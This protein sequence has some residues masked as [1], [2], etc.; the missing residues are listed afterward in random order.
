VIIGSDIPDIGPRHIAAAFGAL[1][2][3]NAVFGPADDG[4]YW[5]IGLRRRPFRPRLCGPVRWSSAH[6][7]ADTRALLGPRVRIAMLETLIDV[8]D[9]KS[10][11][12]WRRNGPGYFS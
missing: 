3:V 11:E 7:L 1:G 6:A 10:L 8:D 9:G 12:R 2:R 5:L 4:G